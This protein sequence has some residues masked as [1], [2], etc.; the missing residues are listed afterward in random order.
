MDNKIGLQRRLQ[1]ALTCACCFI[2]SPAVGQET[3]LSLDCPEFSGGPGEPIQTVRYLAADALEGR[4]SGSAGEACAAQYIAHIFEILGLRPAGNSGFFQEVP[5]A[6]VMTPHAP[7]GVGRNVLGLLRGSDERLAGTVVVIGAHYDHLGFGEFGST[8]KVGAIHNGADDNA[9]GV[10]AMIEAAELLSRGPRPDR[11]ILFVAFTGEELG[12]IGSG[13]Y[14]REPAFPLEN[15]SAMVNLDMVGR[16]EGDAMIVY[17]TGT[18]SQWEEIIPLANE[19][20]SI[21]LVFEPSGF[22]PSDHTSFYTHDIPVLHLFTN[23]HS[24]YH[25]NT[26]DWD[27]IDGDGLVRVSQFAAN[28]TRTIANWPTQLTVVPAVGEHAPRTGGGSEV[29][30]GTVPDF[31]PVDFGV[32][33]A[34]VTDG[35]PAEAAGLQKGDILIRIGRFDIGTLQAFSDALA[36]HKPGDE[37]LLRYVRDG[38]VL[39]AKTRLGDRADRP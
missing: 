19:G 20:P 10:V 28:V 12:L 27:K 1:Q 18:A 6:S 14:T 4:F 33:L 8:G 21:P 22:G 15:T 23:V 24:D 25:G 31:T 37:V 17:G 36:E 35:S 26:D 34:G 7:V 38:R 30:L 13:F 5:L 3:S 11:S 29:W 39:E 9:S 32:L 2:A 16:L